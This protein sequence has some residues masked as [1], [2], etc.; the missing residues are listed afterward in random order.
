MFLFYAS[1][2][3]AN[4]KK[5]DKETTIFDETFSW[6]VMAG[7][8]IHKSSTILKAIEQDSVENFLDLSL[9]IDLYYR[10]FF[11][12]TNHRR[13]SSLNLGLEFGYQLMVNDEWELDIINKSYLSGYAP[14]YS[15]TNDE[16]IPP[17]FQ[18]LADRDSA[19]GIGIRYSRYYDNAELSIDLATLPPRS[20]S[21][22]WIANL[23]YTHLVPYRN[24]DIYYGAELT[25]FSHQ[26]LDY[27]IGI[28]SD[29]ALAIRPE[30]QATSGFKTQL[31]VFAQ[32]PISKKWIFNTGLS[33]S[34][35]SAS[36]Q[37]SPVVGQSNE[38]QLMVGIIYVF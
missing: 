4:D 23:Y 9:L 7:I 20:A 11:I 12:Q 36:F 30:Y 29:E 22:G 32:H 10:G 35:Y 2:T 18:G 6:Q 34:Y 38:T 8:T 14:R 24:W 16:D 37:D 25:Y 17:L 31:E 33:T 3:F 28:D 5:L 13:A 15:W 21:G 27:Y 19:D 26:V 1:S